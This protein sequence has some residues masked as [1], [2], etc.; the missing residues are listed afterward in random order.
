M[1]GFDRSKLKATSKETLDKKDAILKKGFGDRNILKI[2]TGENVIRFFPYHPEGGGDSFVEAKSVSFLEITVPKRDDDNKIIEDQFEIK[3]KPIFNAKVHG[4]YS[5]DLVEEYINFAFQK[6]IPEFVDGDSDKE[7]K[8]KTKFKGSHLTKEQGIMYQDAYVAYAMKAQGKDAEGNWM[9]G[10]VGSLDI[11]KTVKDLMTEKAAELE[12]PDPWSD[13]DEGYAVIITKA[14]EAAKASDWYKFK[15]D[16][17]KVKVDGVGE[18]PVPIKV[19]LTDGQLEAWSKLKPL[20]EL[21]VNSYKRSDFDKQLEG[22]QNFD[23]KMAADFPGF[24]VFAYDEFAD[25]VLECSNEIPDDQAEDHNDLPFE[26]DEP[27]EE[28]KKPETPKKLE[29]PSAP[30]KQ[31]AQVTP[32]KKEA[33]EQEVVVEAQSNEDRLAAIKARLNKKK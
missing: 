30:L 20:Y 1:P 27:K 21:F 17:K 2:E 26:A 33:V 5:K 29:K 9:W 22:L 6:A 4:G 8:I 32:P 12:N 13:P 15:L 24:S 23:R 28:P 11:K 3:S 7:K 19:P 10:E 31:A 16:T 18:V 14:K 25:I